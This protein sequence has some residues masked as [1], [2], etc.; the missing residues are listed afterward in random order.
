MSDL[1]ADI[2]DSREIIARIEELKSDLDCLEEAVEEAQE[3]LEEALSDE[4]AEQAENILREAKQALETW[5]DRDEYETLIALAAE[6]ESSLDWRYGESLIRDNYFEDY[7][8]ELAKDCGM[9]LGDES[10]P[11]NC[12]DWEQAAK[13]LQVDYFSVEFEGETYWIRG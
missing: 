6:C 5:E 8:R 11:L 1:H 7:A 3:R 12:I 10:W 13:E 9:V 2:I 4:A